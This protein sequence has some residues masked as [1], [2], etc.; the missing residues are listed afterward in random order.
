MVIRA[1]KLNLARA[2][3]LAV[4]VDKT[5]DANYRINVINQIVKG[6]IA[7]STKSAVLVKH[8]VHVERAKALIAL[9][10]FIITGTV[11][12]VLLCIRGIHAPTIELEEIAGTVGTGLV[13][14]AH[15]RLLA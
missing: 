8:V 13:L 6:I 15:V 11:E 1:H 4:N 10:V 2:T 3:S 14:I 12:D 5:R 9:Q 7:S